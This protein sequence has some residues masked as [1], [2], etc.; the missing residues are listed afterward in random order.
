MAKLNFFGNPYDWK[1]TLNWIAKHIVIELYYPLIGLLFFVS[2]ALYNPIFLILL[3]IFTPILFFL[4]AFF[5]Y[6]LW[7]RNKN[8]IEIIGEYDENDKWVKGLFYDDKKEVFTKVFTIGFV[9]DI[10]KMG[11]YK[12]K[13]EKRIRDFFVDV[14]LIVGNL[15]GII[16]DK[17]PGITAQKHG[18]EIL[19]RLTKLVSPSHKWLLC[20]SNNHSADFGHTELLL[21]QKKIQGEGFNVI[22]DI[23]CPSYFNKNM[24]EINFVSGTMWNNQRNHCFV[25]QFDFI[26]DYYQPNKFNILL[27]HWHFE[28]EYYV[29][30]DCQ[31]RSKHLILAGMYKKKIPEWAEKILKIIIE[32]L[33]PQIQTLPIFQQLDYLN[34]DQQ[35]KEQIQQTKYYRRKRSKGYDIDLKKWD[36]IYGHHSHV[37]QPIIDYEK[38]LLAYSGGNLT[39][40]QWRKKHRSGLIL[41]CEIG[42]INNSETLVLGNYEWSYTYNERNRK[43]EEVTV[44]IDTKRNSEKSF[45]NTKNKF[46]THIIYIII[47]LIFWSLL[48]LSIIFNFLL[49][50]IYTVV[51]IIIILICYYLIYRP[52]RIQKYSK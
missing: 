24:K 3:Y 4:I 44:K 45:T 18:A 36:L 13:F 31:I 43:D 21:S 47:S 9:G 33:P 35:K 50:F 30:K 1:E 39:S 15:E 27:P 7:K 19:T 51:G 41:K 5:I 22:G 11:K 48:I 10:M 37:P 42:H 20:T 40:S 23:K 29:R 8:K 52:S 14:N 28:N 26:S 12:L 34:R 49:I 38:R 16:T 17:R 6:R 2:V 25:S 46:F 32:V